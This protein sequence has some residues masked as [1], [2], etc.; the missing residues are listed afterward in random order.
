M[1]STLKRA[2]VT[3]FIGCVVCGWLTLMKGQ[4]NAAPG[5]GTSL[6]RSYDLYPKYAK[7]DKEYFS[8]E[9]T[10]THLQPGGAILGEE[11]TKGYF[12]QEVTG[13]RPDGTPIFRVAR[14]HTDLWV[15]GADGKAGPAQRL[16]FAEGFTYEVCF[17]DDFA[18]FPVRTADLPRTS[19]GF[20]EFENIYISQ[21]Y[22]QTMMT[23]AHGGIDQLKKVGTKITVPDSGRKGVVAL[24]Q[25]IVIEVNRG[26]STLEFLGLGEHQ[27]RPAAVLA[28]DVLYL[29]KVP[30][31]LNGRKDGEGREFLRGVIWVSPT[32]GRI[33]GGR[34]NT[35][36]FVAYRDDG[37]WQPSDSVFQGNLE[38]LSEQEYVRETSK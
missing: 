13:L 28:F 14:H 1:Q 21:Q 3:G 36:A 33:L 37:K 6:S 9:I 23:R 25:D 22:F 34:I 38:R 19:A 12:T 17:E 31:H 35:E 16:D 29:L 24:G 7:G 5:R 11:K 15:T 27:G 30:H 26:P 2:L 32:D 10:F 20:M 8:F 4:T 18:L